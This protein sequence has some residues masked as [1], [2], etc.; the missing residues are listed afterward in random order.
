MPMTSPSAHMPDRAQRPHGPIG[1]EEERTIAQLVAVL[2]RE[3]RLV[4]AVRLLRGLTSLRPEN[5]A[6]WSA[7]GGVLTR[8]ERY[9]E[10]LP[11]LSLAI[12]LRP[13][14]IAAYVNRAECHLALGH[15]RAAAADLDRAMA[16]DPDGHHPDAH[17]A[18]CMAFSA[19]RF[20]EAAH[21][22]GLDT[23]PVELDATGTVP[24]NG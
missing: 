12:H 18:R 4:S 9:E 6:Y 7:L 24:K 13:R 1:P 19:Y 15:V 23:I 5:G 8:M 21:Q 22:A 16:L 17:R 20:F 11:I 10:A 3:G 2:Y 14:D